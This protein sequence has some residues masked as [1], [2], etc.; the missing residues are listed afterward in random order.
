MPQFLYRIKPTRVAMLSDGPSA[1]E[2]A[3]VEAHFA[4]L[5]RLATEGVVLVAGRTL[6]RDEHTFGIVVFAAATEAEAAAIVQADPAVERG[7]MTAAL[8]PFRVALLSKDW[9]G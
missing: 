5:E 8:F 6:N 4:Y 7:V 2:Q 3:A 1:S 9:R